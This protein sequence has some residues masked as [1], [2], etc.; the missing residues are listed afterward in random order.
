MGLR[1]EDKESIALKSTV[2][3]LSDELLKVS[4]GVPESVVGRG[5]RPLKQCSQLGVDA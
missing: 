4:D 5:L 2:V 3:G 1:S